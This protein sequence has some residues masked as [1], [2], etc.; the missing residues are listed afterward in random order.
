MRY[1]RVKITRDERTVYNRAC[2]PWEVP[3]LEF[4][5]GEGNLVHTGAFEE[6]SA[7]YPDPKEEFHRMMTT[8]GSDPENGIP[9]VASVYGQAGQGHRALAR[10]IRE[11]EETAKEEGLPRQS[12]SQ[13]IK[14]FSADPL[15]G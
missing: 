14:E 4:M 8:Y 3:V 2:L 12:R 10:A 11:A 15:L 5:F 7:P 13:V 9:H 1:E 6:N